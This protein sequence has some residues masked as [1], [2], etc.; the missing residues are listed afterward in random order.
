[1]IPHSCVVVV[2]VVITVVFSIKKI[3]ISSHAGTR[4]FRWVSELKK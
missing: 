1:M 3:Y 2:V 4:I